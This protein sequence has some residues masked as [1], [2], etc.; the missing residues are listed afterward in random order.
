MFKHYKTVILLLLLLT[1]ISS[2]HVKAASA[3]QINDLIEKEDM[4]D[5]QEVTVQG[6]AI[7]ER[8]DRGNYTWINI[9]DGSNAIGVW[10][11]KSEADKVHY[12][13]DFNSVGD[14]IAL[15]GIFHKACKEH[16]GDTDLHVASIQIIREGQIIKEHVAY[17]KIIVA[18]AAL[19]T[20]FII[21]ILFLKAQ[22]SARRMQQ[23]D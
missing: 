19:L 11:S 5:G 13:G 14:T 12:Y 7:G 2:V 22:K 4:L 18:I 8:M 16:G 10:M 1:T 6:E 23:K 17:S 3:Y 21:F 15:T 20:T 9:N